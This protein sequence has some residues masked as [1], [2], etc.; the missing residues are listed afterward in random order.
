MNQL[1]IK[2]INDYEIGYIT[3]SDL[4]DSE[5]IIT[6]LY[7]WDEFQGFGYGTFLLKCMLINLGRNIKDIEIKLD[8]CSDRTSSCD[9]IYY[10]AGFRMQNDDQPEI[11]SISITKF[12]TIYD[13][14]VKI[15]NKIIDFE[16]ITFLLSSL[17]FVNKDITR[18]FKR[19]ISRFV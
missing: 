3:W 6:G 10:K 17:I 5:I 11:M 7:I 8:D 14:I 15:P 4:S 16:N 12:N 19:V 2:N 9:N 13:F 1:S 18:N